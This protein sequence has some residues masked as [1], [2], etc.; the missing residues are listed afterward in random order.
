V[1]GQEKEPDVGEPK[2]RVDLKLGFEFELKFGLGGAPTPPQ[3]ASDIYLYGLDF[4][5]ALE[6]G[7]LYVGNLVLF[8]HQLKGYATIRSF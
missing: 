3:L 4:V 1:S 6:L 2:L 5:R 8:A 7:K